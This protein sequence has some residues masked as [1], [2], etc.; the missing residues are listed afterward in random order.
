MSWSQ[1]EKKEFIKVLSMSA[2][3]YDKKLSPEAIGLYVRIMEKNTEYGE[4]I[5]AIERHL[6]TGS[7][8]GTFFPK[9]ADLMRLVG[10]DPNDRIEKAWHEVLESL[11]RIGSYRSVSFR[12]KIVNAVVGD[13]G[14]WPVL[15]SKTEDEMK[16]VGN[17]FRRLYRS[18][19][20]IGKVKNVEYLP[21]TTE[22]EN[23]LSGYFPEKPILIGS[24]GPKLLQLEHKNNGSSAIKKMVSEIGCGV[25]GEELEADNV[26]KHNFVYR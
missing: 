2:E 25:S 9:P 7:K 17:E 19:M 8:E 15:G 23:R 22:C 6:S 3:V 10:G 24:E 18:Y 12:D 20:H 13:L 5:Y 26:H 16:F 21:G 4:A 1:N 11:A 14:G